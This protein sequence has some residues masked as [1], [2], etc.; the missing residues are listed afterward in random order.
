LRSPG[1][2]ILLAIALVLLS[3]AAW[4]MTGTYAFFSDTETASAY[5]QA[6]VWG[7][8]EATVD[9][10]PDTLKKT[11]KG[12]PITAYIELPQGYDVNNIDVGSVKLCLDECVYAEDH[13]TAIGDYD[14]DD[15]PDLMVKFDRAEVIGLVEHIVPPAE[16]EFTVRGTIVP[17][18][19]DFEGYD[20]IKVISSPKPPKDLTVNYSQPLLSALAATG[21]REKEPITPCLNLDWEDNTEDDLA[22]YKVYR[23]L[24][25][26]GPYD[27]L[28][29]TEESS[30]P[31][32]GLES[33]TYF[34]VVT[35]FDQVGNESDYSNEAN[36]TVPEPT[37]TDTPTP[38]P[39]PEPI[40]TVE[41][42]PEPTEP[43]EPTPTQE[44]TDTP[45]PEPTATPI[46]T[47]T[48]TPTET[49]SP[50]P[51]STP[52]PTATPTEEPTATPAD[53]PTPAE[54]PTPEA[55]VTP[56]G[57]GGQG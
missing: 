52:E 35:A 28:A 51:T 14:T 39:T 45:T 4:L 43:V 47:D 44:P 23:S 21:D 55:T 2:A 16:V 38:T 49:P 32:C 27:F 53:T 41:P 25:S 33:G 10:D 29:E 36:G 54:T 31:D 56:E 17:P 9:I 11:S 57:E 24:E 34:Y 13:P 42:T 30:Y 3:L 5:F 15:I 19:I 46:P 7:V 20:T 8:I 26:G 1:K 40:E 18:D 6:G 12:V 37:P 50:T 48:P 22:G